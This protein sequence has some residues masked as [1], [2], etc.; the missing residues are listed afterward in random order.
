MV[1]YAS[2]RFSGKAD[3]DIDEF[4]KDYRI[5]LTVVNITTANV[6]GKKCRLNHVR[7]ENALANIA[8]IVALNNANITATII[9]ASD[10]I[11]LPTLPV[12]ATSITVILVHNVHI[13]EDWSLTRGY[14]VD[15]DTAT[16]APNGVLNNNN[17]IL[18]CG[19]HSTSDMIHIK[20]SWRLY[21][22]YIIRGDTVQ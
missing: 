2:K 5:Y 7:Y 10:G 11:L 19:G 1:E 16:N 3:E 17:H 14:H 22:E 6:G 12:K 8:T 9:N 4:I 18:Y 13:D 20:R 15:A 21:L